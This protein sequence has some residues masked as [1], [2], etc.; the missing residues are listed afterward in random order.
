MER[1]G[2]VSYPIRRRKRYAKV[3]AKQKLPVAHEEI[4]RH[5]VDLKYCAGGRRNETHYAPNNLS[6]LSYLKHGITGSR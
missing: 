6:P 3:R 2:K 4:A 5:L 1:E